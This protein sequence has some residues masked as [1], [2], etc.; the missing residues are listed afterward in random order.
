MKHY[1]KAQGLMAAWIRLQAHRND[2]VGQ[3]AQV[4]N[5]PGSNAPTHAFR[6]VVWRQWALS[7]GLTNDHVEA[8]LSEYA[9]LSLTEKRA[10]YDADRA[11]R[12]Q[13][14]QQ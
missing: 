5:Q 11:Q 13:C 1:P 8:M 14:V 6:I 10:A 3:F 4:V 2:L 12:A 9:K 7:H